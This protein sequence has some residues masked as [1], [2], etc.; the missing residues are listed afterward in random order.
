VSE[1]AT[2]SDEVAP[3]QPGAPLLEVT[4]LVKHF[5]A[6]RG[7]FGGHAKVH[8]VDGVDLEVR[9]GEVLA[10][11]GESGSGKSTLARCVLRLIDPTEGR[12]VFDGRDVTGL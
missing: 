4:G 3:P 5:R 1:L 7:V 12:V 9:P 8:A 6:G 11:V 10:I 2:F